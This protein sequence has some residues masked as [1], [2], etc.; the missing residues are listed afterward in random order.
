MKKYKFFLVLFWAFFVLATLP[1]NTLQPG[2][3]HRAQ[4]GRHEFI[5]E[6]GREILTIQYPKQFCTSPIPTAVGSE[7]VASVRIG[8]VT[9][10]TVSLIVDGNP[11]D[12]GV[13]FWQAQEP[14]GA[15]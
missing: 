1:G 14:T 8:V 4:A 15:K 6:A 7:Q 5:F 3:T 9:P 12:A 10:S 11:G 13:I 2:C